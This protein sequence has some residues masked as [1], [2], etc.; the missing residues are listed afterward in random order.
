MFIDNDHKNDDDDDDDVPF[1]AET[2]FN[3][4]SFV[5]KWFVFHANQSAKGR[6]DKVEVNHNNNNNNSKPTITTITVSP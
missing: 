3:L 1:K 4:M 2:S 6:P 5:V